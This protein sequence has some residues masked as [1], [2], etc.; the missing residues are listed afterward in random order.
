MWEQRDFEDDA[1]FLAEFLAA[2][3]LTVVD[4]DYH[5]QAIRTA[6]EQGSDELA[7][8]PAV[9]LGR[10]A[11]NTRTF[12]YS[13]ELLEAAEDGCVFR[14]DR[15]ESLRELFARLSANPRRP[16]E[17]NAC[18]ARIERVPVFN[19]TVL[20]FHCSVLILDELKAEFSREN[21][22]EFAWSC[23][24]QNMVNQLTLSDLVDPPT[25]SWDDME[26]GP[27]P[28]DMTFRKPW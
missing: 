23:D 13:K 26:P 24:T 20:S 22:S 8:V 7:G 2:F 9:W 14:G 3:E 12:E 19:V 28:G 27:G 11:E 25:G 6:L 18:W 21:P 1:L 5:S 17:D 15:L 10:D 16:V 4:L